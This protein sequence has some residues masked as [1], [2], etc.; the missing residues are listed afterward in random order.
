M[1]SMALV[2]LQ[3]EIVID[4]QVWVQNQVNRVMRYNHMDDLYVLHQLL[5]HIAIHKRK[6]KK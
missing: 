3:V 1:H 5:L 4:E 6:R 2:L